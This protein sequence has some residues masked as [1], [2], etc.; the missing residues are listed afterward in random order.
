VSEAAG[1]LLTQ[2]DARGELLAFIAVHQETLAVAGGLFSA[3]AGND[4]QDRLLALA[5]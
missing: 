5:L 4:Y 2:V 3:L 1:D